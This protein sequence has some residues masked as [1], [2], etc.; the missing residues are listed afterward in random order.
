MYKG[1]IS[2]GDIIECIFPHENHN[3]RD[4]YAKLRPC[5]VLERTDNEDFSVYKIDD[6]E[7]IATDNAINNSFISSPPLNP[8]FPRSNRFP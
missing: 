2:V 3:K 5:L 1:N 7:S 6:V 8:E 4:G